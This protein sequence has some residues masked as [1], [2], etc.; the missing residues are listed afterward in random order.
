MSSNYMFSFRRSAPAAPAA[1]PK[2]LAA[3]V[4]PKALAA[5]NAQSDRFSLNRLMNYKATGGCRS[6]G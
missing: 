3:P 5:P 4:A 2:A 6:C 1:A